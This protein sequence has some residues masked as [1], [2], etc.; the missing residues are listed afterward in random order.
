VRTITDQIAGLQSPEA[1]RAEVFGSFSTAGLALMGFGRTLQER[2]AQAA[3]QLL[4]VQKEM[5]GEIRDNLAP[6]VG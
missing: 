3:E 1:N 4:G 6:E 5:L 2:T